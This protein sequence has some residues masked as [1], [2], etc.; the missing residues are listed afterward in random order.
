[1]EQNMFCYQCPEAQ[2][3]VLTFT[4]II[5]THNTFIGCVKSI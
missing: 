5:S 1:M 3:E 2:K 4:H